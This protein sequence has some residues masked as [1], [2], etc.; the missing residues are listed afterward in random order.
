MV[1]VSTGT[2][3]LGSVASVRTPTIIERALSSVAWFSVYQ[4]DTWHWFMLKPAS[5]L[6]ISG[7]MRYDRLP[8]GR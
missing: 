2:K 6:A 3:V 1:Q 7:E 5:L 4:N 8:A